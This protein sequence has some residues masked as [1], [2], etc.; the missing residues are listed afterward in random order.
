MNL[1]R[2]SKVIAGPFIFLQFFP[3]WAIAYVVIFLISSTFAPPAIAQYV[4]KAPIILPAYTLRELSGYPIN[5]Y[6]VFRSVQGKAEA[7]PFQIDEMTRYEDF[8]LDQGA[9]PNMHE[10]D[11]VFDNADELSFMGEDVG[12]IAPIT[13]WIG[14][15]PDLS[16][17]LKAEHPSGKKGAIY[18]GIWFSR[19]PPLSNKS[20]VSFNLPQAKISTSRYAYYFDP[21]NYLVVKGIDVLNDGKP[22]RLVETCRFFLNA[23]L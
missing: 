7:I 18:V 17:E 13:S 23:D 10:G 22:R 11:G 20:Y 2:T 21:K 19:A 3:S 5:T 16:Y 15:A 8:V 1:E 4:H 14:P 6:R 12:D 9:S